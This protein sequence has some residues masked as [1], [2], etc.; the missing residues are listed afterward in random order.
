MKEINSLLRNLFLILIFLS[1]VNWVALADPYV[2]MF[3]MP[4]C[5]FFTAASTYGKCTDEVLD[6][7]ASNPKS[8][9]PC[10]GTRQWYKFVYGFHCHGTLCHTGLYASAIDG[11]TSNV[12][13]VTGEG[14]YWCTVDCGSGSYNTDTVE[15]FY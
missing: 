5:Q 9:I 14:K 10:I 2:A 3:C 6:L 11:A 13:T 4:G 12:Y 7:Y 15:F 1:G 8:V